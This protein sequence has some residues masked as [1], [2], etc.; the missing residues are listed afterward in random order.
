MVP[1]SLSESNR[2]AGR[3]DLIHR[4][5]AFAKYNF[6]FLD[7]KISIVSQRTHLSF[8]T[9][10]MLEILHFFSTKNDFKSIWEMQIE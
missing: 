1:L 2:T 9:L 10:I 3:S 8:T 4:E 6:G 5:T 7:Y